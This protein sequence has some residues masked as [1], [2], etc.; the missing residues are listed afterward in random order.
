MRTDQ[1]LQHAVSVLLLG[2]LLVACTAL[3]AQNLQS[4]TCE[5]W[6]TARKANLSTAVQREWLFGYVNGWRDAQLAFAGKDVFETMPALEVLI[7]K[8]NAF[9]EQQPDAKVNQVLA[10]LL[11]PASQ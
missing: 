10:G 4:R 9:C 1:P 3:H 6:N 8:T 5:A 7:E 11:P 2:V